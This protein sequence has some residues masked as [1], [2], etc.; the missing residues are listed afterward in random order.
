MKK[1]PPGIVDPFK[2]PKKK[3]DLPSPYDDPYGTLGEEARL[4]KPPVLDLDGD[5]YIIRFTGGVTPDAATQAL[6]RLL[7]D[8]NKTDKAHLETHGVWVAREEPDCMI[9]KSLYGTVSVYRDN[10]DANEIEVFRRIGCA[11]WSLPHKTVLETHK[12]KI[13]KRG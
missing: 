6:V 3:V 2:E 7:Y 4:R 10:I 1:K 5:S 9:L 8:V 12:V 11:L 13:V